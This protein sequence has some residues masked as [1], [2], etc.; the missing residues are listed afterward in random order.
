MTMTDPI[1]RALAQVEQEAHN[2]DR[3]VRAGEC[4]SFAYCSTAERDVWKA[5]TERYLR[6]LREIDAHAEV[7]QN[8]GC[9]SAF[10]ELRRIRQITAACFP[11][12]REGSS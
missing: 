7:G 6:A 9:T 1:A 5:A 10:A 12:E 4:E 2:A 11:P 3:T 8:N